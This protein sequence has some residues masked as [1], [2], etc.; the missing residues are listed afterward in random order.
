MIGRQPPN[1]AERSRI[2]HRVWGAVDL[3]VRGMGDIEAWK[4]ICDAINT[5]E[6]MVEMGK[7]PAAEHMPRVT[8]AIA[9]MVAARECEPGRMT[10]APE[11]LQA[12]KQVAQ[13]Y[14]AALERF[15]QQTLAE[16]RTRVVMRIAQQRNAPSL[17]VVV[18][19]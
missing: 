16:A 6:A 14:D 10:M 1:W 8:S 12:L 11:L 17:G 7:L 18:V 9:G 19:D 4:D 5:L 3:M 13:D 2:M 15:S